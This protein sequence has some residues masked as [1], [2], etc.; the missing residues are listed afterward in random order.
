MN[1]AMSACY[2]FK[3]GEIITFKIDFDQVQYNDDGSVIVGDADSSVCLNGNF[4][5]DLLTK[6]YIEI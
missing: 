5:F 2:P 3:R 1:N 4:L 6:D